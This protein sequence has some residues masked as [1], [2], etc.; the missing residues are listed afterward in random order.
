MPRTPICPEAISSTR[1]ASVSR[2]KG[3]AISMIDSSF[4][5]S[6]RA[7]TTA[8][9]KLAHARQADGAGAETVRG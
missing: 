2:S 5:M 9:S 3:R 1:T 4:M 8:I 7:S 6:T